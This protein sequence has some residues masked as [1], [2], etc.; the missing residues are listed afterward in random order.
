ME[1]INKRVF[2]LGML[3]REPGEKLRDVVIALANTGMF[4]P[5]E[6][7]RIGK[8]LEAEGYIHDGELTVKGMIEA[9][10]AE[11]EFRL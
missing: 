2:L 4:T 11:S 3:T 1:D 8:E 5:K 10:K 9:K 7:K 6:G